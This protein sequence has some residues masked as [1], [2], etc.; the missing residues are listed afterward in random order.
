MNTSQCPSIRVCCDFTTACLHSSMP[1]HL[2]WRLLSEMMRNHVIVPLTEA[3]IQTELLK[4][5]TWLK[6]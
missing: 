3:V 5:Y 4:M 1:I 2:E 6:P